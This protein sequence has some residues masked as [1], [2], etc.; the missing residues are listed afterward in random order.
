MTMP[1]IAQQNITRWD[2]LS[3]GDGVRMKALINRF[4]EEHPDIKISGTTL[5]WGFPIT[6]KFARPSQ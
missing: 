2:F 1:A 5:E 4:N 3:G 6:P